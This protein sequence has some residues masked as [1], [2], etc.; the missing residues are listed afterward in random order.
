MEQGAYAAIIGESILLSLAPLI[1]LLRHRVS[2]VLVLLSPTAVGIITAPSLA[3]AVFV[4]GQ[5]E[6]ALI[7]IPM[8]HLIVYI[9][10]GWLA[11]RCPYPSS[12][13]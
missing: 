11:A 9:A 7:A 3:W 1:L 8:A 2:R 6:W 5:E 12:R 4:D 13:H 10:T